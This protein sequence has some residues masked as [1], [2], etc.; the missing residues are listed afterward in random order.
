MPSLPEQVKAAWND[1]DGAVVLAT[2]DPQGVPNAIYATCV[3][4]HGDDTVVIADN[5]FNKTQQNIAAGSRGA[6]LFIT[7]QKKSFQVKG[8]IEYHTA[9]PVFDEMKGWNP[10]KYPGRAAAAIKAEEVYSGGNRL[11]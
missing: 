2:V 5:Y 4:L 10:S 7:K 3:S 9:G 1:R 8:R 11:D 6:V